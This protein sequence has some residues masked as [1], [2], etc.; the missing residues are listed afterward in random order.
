[1]WFSWAV[2][3]L[4]RSVRNRSFKAR[5]GSPYPLFPLLQRMAMPHP[6]TAAS[7]ALGK[8]MELTHGIHEREREMN[9]TVMH[10]TGTVESCV[11][12]A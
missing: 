9:L 7:L 11:T 1:M 4:I 12:A 2:V 6:E 5:Y 3:E 10:G 8:E